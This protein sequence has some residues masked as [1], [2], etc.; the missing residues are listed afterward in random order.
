MAVSDKSRKRIARRLK[1]ILAE[2]DP[3]TNNSA[4]S[5]I[6]MISTGT[7]HLCIDC[8]SIDGAPALDK[9]SAHHT[10]TCRHSG[11]FKDPAI[12]TSCPICFKN[13][14]N[15]HEPHSLLQM[16]LAGYGKSLFHQDLKAGLQGN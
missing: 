13:I 8:L 11:S 5:T 4:Y 9:K 6:I 16:L 14:D 3:A 12:I 1:K 2:E 10:V 15:Q 7:G